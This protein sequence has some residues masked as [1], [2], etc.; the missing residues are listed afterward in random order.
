M[1]SERGRTVQ[2]PRIS[3]A[4]P[5]LT[6]RARHLI[7]VHRQDRG[8]RPYGFTPASSKRLNTTVLPSLLSA[9]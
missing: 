7:T 1:R 6:P 9:E 3:D 2:H 8:I 5:R 4:S